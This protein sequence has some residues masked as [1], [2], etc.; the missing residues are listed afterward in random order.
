MGQSDPAHK[1]TTV[2]VYAGVGLLVVGFTVYALYSA[3][4]VVENESVL[5]HVSVVKVATATY[6]FLLIMVAWSWIAGIRM[7]NEG[8]S[9][10]LNHVK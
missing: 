4:R 10:I 7:I 2:V 6:S 3:S 5:G 1:I 8:R 9:E